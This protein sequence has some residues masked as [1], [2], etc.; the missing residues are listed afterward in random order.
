MTIFIMVRALD[1]IMHLY[2]YS[3]MKVAKIM[4]ASIKVARY[5]HSQMIVKFTIFI[6]VST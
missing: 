4:A 2:A 1:F 3:T 6:I 5:I